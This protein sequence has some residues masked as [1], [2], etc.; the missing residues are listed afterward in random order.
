MQTLTPTPAESIAIG[1]GFC[2]T[3]NNPIESQYSA[4]KLLEI[5][6]NSLLKLLK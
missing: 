6:A 2:L 3:K 4:L 1:W 5:T